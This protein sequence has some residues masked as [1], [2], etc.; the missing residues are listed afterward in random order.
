MARLIVDRAYA[1]GA[2]RVET[3]FVDEQLRRSA[4]V[5]R[6]EDALRTT[7][8]YELAMIDEMREL[9][10]AAI[11]VDSVADRPMSQG[12]DP[13]LVTAR[14][15]EYASALSAALE[16]EEIPWT[17]IVAPNPSW[18][19]RVFG[20]P[21]L[22]RLWDA[23]AIAARLDDP[24]PVA[25]WQARVAELQ[26]RCD[27]LNELR[28]TT[29]HVRGPGTDLTI[30][31][32]DGAVWLGGGEVSKRGINYIPNLPTEEVFTSPD[33]R[34]VSGT[35]RITA[36]VGLN[37]SANVT[38]LQLRL[39]EGRITD[40]QA[41]TDLDVVLAQLD[42]D[43]R[44]RYLGEIALV[45][46]ASSGVARAGVLFQETLLDENISSHIAWGYAFEAT[47]PG[48]PNS[49]EATKLAAG[50]NVST[51]H[52]DVP[53]GGADVDFDGLMSDGSRIPIIRGPDWVLE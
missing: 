11:F 38:G 16:T 12:V 17:I 1:A 30:P 8:R 36:P 40:V 47:V 51:V 29:I 50:L 44:A 41:D 21:D 45:D 4:I 26:A 9:G 13:A 28:P 49:D 20:E 19:E 53:I 27:R 33:W 34:R 32:P 22:D 31:L 10:A 2:R 35:V 7:Y 42:Q 23:I 3:R 48:L 6:A 25:S 15:R 5:H 39:E 37:V 46:T 43:E 24:D 52:T 14:R 18:A